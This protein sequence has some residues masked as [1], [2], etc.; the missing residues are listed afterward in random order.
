M[1]DKELET[2]TLACLGVIALFIIL[3]PL[4]WF[5]NG[6]CVKTL[7]D[8]FVLPVFET[9]PAI[10]IW[11][12]VGLMMVVTT[13]TDRMVFYQVVQDPKKSTLTHS[14]VQL[15]VSPII[16]IAVGYVLKSLFL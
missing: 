12:A 6:L 2:A 3:P 8:W 11:Q 15:L 10:S 13:L 16:T 1:K 7:W 14:L 9:A 5:V 4:A